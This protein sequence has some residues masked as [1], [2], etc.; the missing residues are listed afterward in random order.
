MLEHF[1]YSEH[2]LSG[3][4]VGAL[5]RPVVVGLITSELVLEP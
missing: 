1:H 3:S 2:K 4:G 5:D